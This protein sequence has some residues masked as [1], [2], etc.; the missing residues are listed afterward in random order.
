MYKG[1]NLQLAA[2]CLVLGSAFFAPNRVEPWQPIS[3]LDFDGSTFNWDAR[4]H[5]D[6]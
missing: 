5:A 2:S 1:R 4:K 3:P 6:A